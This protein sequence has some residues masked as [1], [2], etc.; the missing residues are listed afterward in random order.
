MKV[1]GPESAQE[2]GPVHA[3][4]ACACLV[5]C[6]A[7]LRAQGSTEDLAAPALTDA[8][9]ASRLGVV[10]MHPLLLGRMCP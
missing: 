10:H 9:Q 7:L 3:C 8:A 4:R 2:R 6:T 1:M 5:A